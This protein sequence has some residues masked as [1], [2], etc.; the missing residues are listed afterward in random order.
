MM[1]ERASRS[2]R[3]EGCGDNCGDYRYQRQ[4]Q[5]ERSVEIGDRAGVV[6]IEHHH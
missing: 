4:Y 5:I 3:N 6:R 2:D 1:M